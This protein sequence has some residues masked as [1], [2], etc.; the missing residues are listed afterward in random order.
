VAIVR[1]CVCRV[2][3]HGMCAQQLD[4]GQLFPHARSANSIGLGSRLADHHVLSVFNAC[5]SC[6]RVSCRWHRKSWWCGVVVNKAG[7]YTGSS[8]GCHQCNQESRRV[9]VHSTTRTRHSTAAWCAAVQLPHVRVVCCAQ[10]IWRCAQPIWRCIANPPASPPSSPA[11]SPAT[12]DTAAPTGTSASRPA[13]PPA[14]P[15]AAPH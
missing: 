4:A 3:C 14:S 11:A 1:A 9:C 5:G 15:T 12:D 13:A 2:V 8:R 7:S 6:A 10:P